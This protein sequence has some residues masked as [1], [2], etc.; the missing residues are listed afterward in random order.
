[1]KRRLLMSLCAAGAS[2]VIG[3][4]SSEPSLS[5]FKSGFQTN[6]TQFAQLGRDMQST[7]LGAKGKSGAQIQS[8]FMALAARISQQ[9]DQLQ[10]LKAP[11]KYKA[12]LAALV[13]GFRAVGA[14]LKTI[15]VEAAGT[16]TTALRAAT[17]K[18][19]QD[20]AQVRSADR[21]LTSSLGLPQTG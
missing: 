15:A 17:M 6:K 14:D 3:C 11:S 7:L 2:A 21:T 9:A 18:L 5:S 20:A 19:L 4:G 10:R 8:E 13:G 12:Q 16:S 1:M